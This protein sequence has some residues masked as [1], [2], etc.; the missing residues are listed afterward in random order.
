[1]IGKRIVNHQ[2]DRLKLV[3]FATLNRHSQFP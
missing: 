3:N 2:M 1:M